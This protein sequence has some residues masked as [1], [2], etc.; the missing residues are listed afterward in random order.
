[1]QRVRELGMFNPKQGDSIKF[2]LLGLRKPHESME[3]PE[4]I[5]GT[6]KTRPSKSTG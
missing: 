5:G 1:M 2:L 3:E 4:E 6:K